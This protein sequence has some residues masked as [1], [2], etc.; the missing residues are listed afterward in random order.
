MTLIT[1]SPGL[2]DRDYTGRH[3][4]F[5]EKLRQGPDGSAVATV[6][7]SAAQYEAEIS[8]SDRENEALRKTIADHLTATGEWLEAE[9]ALREEVAAYQEVLRQKDAELLA[10]AQKILNLE[11]ILR[12]IALEIPAEGSAEA[13]AVALNNIDQILSE[14]GVS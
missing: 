7:D 11:T 8:R 6:T 14:G 5:G 13:D 4:R 10:Q 12:R 2:L 3:N 1:K 9:Q